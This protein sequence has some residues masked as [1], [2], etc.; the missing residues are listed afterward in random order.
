M[1]ETTKARRPDKWPKL[2][3]AIP[4]YPLLHSL[5]DTPYSISS[6]C[7]FGTTESGAVRS[8]TSAENITFANSCARDRNKQMPDRNSEPETSIH[9][10]RNPNLQKHV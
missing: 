4:P 7:R 2:K 3:L 9:Q 10:N 6:V 5:C 1:S 8:I